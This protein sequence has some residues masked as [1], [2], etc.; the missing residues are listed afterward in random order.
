MSSFPLK[1][2]Q[3]SLVDSDDELCDV[4]CPE[5]HHYPLVAGQSQH[6]AATKH[7]WA[8]GVSSGFQ[9]AEDP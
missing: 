7:L 2:S 3:F 1:T 6:G 9:W 4:S 8:L 5:T